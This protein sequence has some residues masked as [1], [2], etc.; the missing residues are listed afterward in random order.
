MYLHSFQTDKEVEEALH[1]YI[2]FYNQQRFQ[3]RL[4]NLSPIEYRTQVA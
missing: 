3:S 2:N 4:K 1:G